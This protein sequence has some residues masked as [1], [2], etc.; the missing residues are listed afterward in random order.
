MTKMQQNA[1]YKGE[2]KNPST[3]TTKTHNTKDVRVNHKIKEVG[4]PS[5]AESP[6]QHD[7]S[8]GKS[9][10]CSPVAVRMVCFAKEQSVLISKAQP[11]HKYFISFPRVPTQ[12]MSVLVQMKGFLNL[13]Y[14]LFICSSLVRANKV[15]R[16]CLPY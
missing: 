1:G 16:Y 13:F 3:T 14:C 12:W 15:I 5:P 6:G 7:Q 2:E 9:H 10:V 4:L 11:K 8:L